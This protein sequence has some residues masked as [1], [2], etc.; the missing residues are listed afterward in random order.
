MS[1]CQARKFLA[2]GRCGGSSGS[3]TKT[4][5]DDTSGVGASFAS[6]LAQRE[7]MDAKMWASP[8][9]EEEQ[10]N[11]QKIPFTEGQGV[12]STPFT[13]GQGVRSTPFT[14]TTTLA[15]VKQ[16]VLPKEQQRN[17]DIDCVLE[18]DY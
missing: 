16:E 13:E 15:V 11:T 7:A 3:F 18:G 9:K 4:K 8:T 2:G 5:E 10:K 1:K 17:A 12:R 14:Q 6:L